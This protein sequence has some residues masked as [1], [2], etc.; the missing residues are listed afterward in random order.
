MN[1]QQNAQK[2]LLKIF[3]ETRSSGVNDYPVEINDIKD[4]LNLNDVET[5][6][7]IDLLVSKGLVNYRAISNSMIQL[8]DKGK[9]QF[10]KRVP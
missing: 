6:T 8:S 2:I 7:A 9:L 10:K 4:D 5:K 1:T 3:E